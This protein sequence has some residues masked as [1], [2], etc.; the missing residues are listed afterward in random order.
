MYPLSSYPDVLLPRLS[1]GLDIA[2]LSAGIRTLEE[3]VTPMASCDISNPP[4]LDGPACGAG[5]I[6]R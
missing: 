6:V 1:A 5:G 4:C 2:M 3:T